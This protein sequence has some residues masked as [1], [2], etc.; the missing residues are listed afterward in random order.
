[1]E[2]V[3]AILADEGID[4]RPRTFP[5]LPIGDG[6]GVFVILVVGG[7]AYRSLRA[8]LDAF[9]T[10]AGEDAWKR[11]ARK[12]GEDAR[13]RCPD[14]PPEMVEAEI[15]LQHP[16]TGERIFLRSSHPDEA[17]RKAREID[18]EPNTWYVW[19]DGEWVG[20]PPG[21]LG[22]TPDPDEWERI[23]TRLLGG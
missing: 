6:V 23:R 17:F 9:F 19:Q 14:V 12:L 13:E 4:A 1:M 18:F 5:P 16:E 20:V 10:A 8:F 3:R 22:F 7:L 15:E 2:R 21:E 11:V